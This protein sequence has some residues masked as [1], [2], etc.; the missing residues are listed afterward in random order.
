MVE[1]WKGG[2]VEKWKGGKVERWKG[3]R[4]EKLKGGIHVILRVKPHPLKTSL[5]ELCLSVP[6]REKPNSKL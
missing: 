6:L 4:V 1:K 2:K 3:E 5:C